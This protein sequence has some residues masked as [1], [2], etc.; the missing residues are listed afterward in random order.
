MRED[1]EILL[2]IKRRI[3]ADPKN[4]TFWWKRQGKNKALNPCKRNSTST[5]YWQ[6]IDCTD[7]RVTAIDLSNMSL[8]GT[9]SPLLAKLSQL[10]RLN[11]SNNH[12]TGPI[13]E[14]PA[15]LE[16]LDLGS[17]LLEFGIPDSLGALRNLTSL[18]VANNRL[19]GAIPASFEN[20]QLLSTLNISGNNL[21]GEISPGLNSC[22]RL[23]V[24]DLSGNGG[25]HGVV[26]FQGLENLTTL[27]LQGNQLSGNL[28][29]S[30][31]TFPHL[32]DLDVSNN[33]MAGALPTTMSRLLTVQR[34]RLAGNAFTGSLPDAVGSLTSLRELDVS[35]NGLSGGLPRTLASLGSLTIFNASHNGFNGS[36]PSL[37]GIQN[38]RS[39]DASFNNL[40]GG[41]SKD[42]V[43]FTTLVDLNVSYNSLSGEVPS[44]VEHDEV[45]SRSFLHNI[46]LCGHNVD[47][48]CAGS[49]DSATARIVSISVGSSVAFVAMVVVMYICCRRRHKG[50]AR[51]SASVSAE[52]DIKL[53]PEEVRR[54]TQNFSDRNYI[55]VGSASTVYRGVLQD[56]TVVAVKRLGIQPGEISEGG[57]KVLDDGFAALTQVRDWTLVK[58]LG[59]CCRPEV[60]ALVMEYMPNGTLSHLMYPPREAE[61]VREFNW[62]HRFNAA[63]AVAQGLKYLHHECRT[64]TVHGDLKPNNILF[65]T[66]MEARIAD[67]G[68]KRL[69]ASHGLGLG[70]SFTDGYTA[71]EFAASPQGSTIKGD[72]YSFGIIV[73]EMISGRSPQSLEAGQRLPQWIRATIANS[74]SLHNVLD[75][76]LMSELREQQQRMAMVLGVALL[77]ARENPQERPY[78]TEV[79]KMLNHIHT[80]P[81]DGSR[82]GSKR[83]LRSSLSTHQRNEEIRHE[84]PGIDIA[85]SPPGT[86]SAPPLATNP[87][88]SH[89]TPISSAPM[90]SSPENR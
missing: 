39:F 86:P 18:N 32:L 84:V 30:L 80:R 15:A 66:F 25:I 12:F 72:V 21:T 38:L 52:L 17:N 33:G 58:V 36:L 34:L 22:S 44:F 60:K 70:V 8:S 69:L 6:G 85:P 29:V 35:G 82:R 61:V 3:T 71:P 89:W 90:R 53:T 2:Q 57:E 26:P 31:D 7:K 83:K 67:F 42:F 81:Q 16:T 49:S 10:K 23:S 27:Y 48:Q 41:V 43:N 24:V 47:R 79:L 75:P 14:L 87:S 40:T 59:Y 46:A 4:I 9:L 55:G 78:I 37:A 19:T 50:R 76:I 64:S 74:K 13:P 63:I 11:L 51:S 45:N 5:Q 88:L 54:A 28:V 73:L 65:S 56:A 20:L 62:T 68:V 77:C 1:A